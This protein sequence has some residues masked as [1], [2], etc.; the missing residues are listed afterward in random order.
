M[1]LG[2]LV[3]ICLIGIA[4]A[5]A[6]EAVRTGAAAFGDWRTDGPGVCRLITPA[7]PPAPFATKSA[8]GRSQR[9]ART[10]VDIPK[11]PPG[12]AVELF[13]SGLNTPR[14]IRIA[15]NGDIFVAE[16]GAGR[17]RVFRPGAAGSEPAQGEIFADGVQRVYGIAFYASGSDPKFVYVATSDSVL[18]FP[19][20]SRDVKASGP[21]E[22]VASVPGG[23][24]HRSRVLA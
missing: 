3:L 19:Y 11:A 1:R 23:G 12:F 14:T 24:G 2:F 10:G 17:V 9:A 15:P 7:D 8:A 4:P 21:A 20:R 22:R 16:T 6:D 18:R 13:A 5:F